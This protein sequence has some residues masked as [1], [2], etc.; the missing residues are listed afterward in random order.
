MMLPV[1]TET[2]NIEADFE[3]G[4]LKIRIPKPPEAKK[5]TRQIEIH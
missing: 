2:E 4:V 3:D 5:E 1:E